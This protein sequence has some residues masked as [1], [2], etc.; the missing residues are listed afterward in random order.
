MINIKKKRKNKDYFNILINNK[1]LLDSKKKAINLREEKEAVLLTKYLSRFNEIEKIYQDNFIR[2]VQFKYSLSNSD[3]KIYIN[4]V[5]KFIDTDATCYRAEKKSVLETIQKK[6]YDPLVLYCKEKYGIEL[7]VQHGVMPLKQEKNN[8][9]I[10]QKKLISLN[11]LLLTFFY[12]ITNIT[13]SIIIS[14]NLLDDNINQEE[15]W[16]IINTEED[17]NSSRWGKDEE[18]ETKLLLKKKLFIDII[19]FKKKFQN[20][21]SET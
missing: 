21:R 8:Y 10:M 6:K 16:D 1:L 4:K 19:N 7:L 2:L 20:I 15:A 9:E 13:N 12:H 18:K 14:F 3:K 11:P 5:L 17:F